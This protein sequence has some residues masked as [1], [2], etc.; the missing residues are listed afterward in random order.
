MGKLISGGEAGAEWRE[1]RVSVP[2]PQTPRPDP[3]AL[4][5]A[6]HAE[7]AAQH[8]AVLAATQAAQALLET[9]GHHLCPEEKEKLQRNVTELKAH[10]ES[11]LAASETAVRRTRSLQEELHKFDADCGE[12]EQWLQQAEQDLQNLEAGADDLSGLTAKLKRQKSFSEDVIS[13]KG[14]LRYITIAGNRVLEAAKSCS[15]REG[16]G[17]ADRDQVDTSAAHREVQGRLDRAT[18]RF[19]SLYTKVSAV[20]KT[21][22]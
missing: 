6:Q 21:D 22:V 17:R 7:L 12:F 20:L 9:Q 2:R 3:A 13:H 19:R 8:Q 18:E 11:A 1:A 15:G 16:G 4:A 14:D 5:Q 10:F